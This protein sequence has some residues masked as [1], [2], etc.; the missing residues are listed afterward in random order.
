MTGLP[1]GSGESMRAMRV[2]L[3]EIA[4]VAAAVVVNALILSQIVGG[5]SFYRPSTA[6]AQPYNDGLPCTLPSE[7]ISGFCEQGV[8]CD[9]SC[10]GTTESCNQPANLGQCTPLLTAP[11]M[12]WPGQ[13]L[14]AT[15]L[16]LLGWFGIRRM[17]ESN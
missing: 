1:V 9:Q 8:C 3:K 16:T 7:C 14:A 15:L 12:S 5:L 10:N 4:A 17:R 2:S 6:F 11:S 13:L